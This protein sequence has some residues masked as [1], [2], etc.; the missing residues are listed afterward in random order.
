M[1]RE[2]NF[3]WLPIDIMGS[4]LSNAKDLLRFDGIYYRLGGEIYYFYRF[5]EDGMVISASDYDHPEVVI[6][7][8]DKEH[9]N[10]GIYSIKG[11][12][13]Y[14]TTTSS[15]GSVEYKGM[16]A[17]DELILDS[18]SFINGFKTFNQHYQF[19]KQ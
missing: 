17:K 11:D 18:H 14:F 9:E 2:L 8:L 1:R 4:C 3:N 13:I 5:Y 12:Q 10:R 6:N 7:W 16:I 15:Q 19:W